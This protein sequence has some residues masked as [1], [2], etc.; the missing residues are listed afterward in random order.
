MELLHFSFQS[1]RT[2]KEDGAEIHRCISTE[3]NGRGIPITLAKD[4]WDRVSLTDR[5]L[6]PWSVSDQLFVRLKAAFE[7]RV[8]EIPADRRPSFIC[9]LIPNITHR[10]KH[11]DHVHPYVRN[12]NGSPVPLILAHI[13]RCPHESYR[14]RWEALSADDL[15]LLQIFR[16]VGFISS[17]DFSQLTDARLSPFFEYA[18]LHWVKQVLAHE[19]RRESFRR[20]GAQGARSRKPRSIG[21]ARYLATY[22]IGKG[23]ETFHSF[24][25]FLASLEP[26]EQFTDRQIELEEKFNPNS[27]QVLELVDGTGKKNCYS[28]EQLRKNF[29]RAKSDT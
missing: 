8:K 21:N 28:R 27:N 7:E 17:L 11:G 14:D 19:E 12:A 2:I 25:E 29:S 6:M 13:P 1:T 23:I 15:V 20:S 5:C 4:L 24:L 26:D 3:M 16:I 10:D 9:D 18:R 22:A